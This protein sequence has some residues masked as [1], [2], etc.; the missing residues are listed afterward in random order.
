[1]A[2]IEITGDVR[3]GAGSSQVSAAGT[4]VVTTIIPGT[5]VSATVVTGGQGEQGPQGPAGVAGASVK[6]NVSPDESPD[7]ELT[8][9]TV[10]ESYIAGSLIVFLNGLA[11][12]NFTET[13]SETFTFDTAPEVGDIIK[14]AYSISD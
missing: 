1:M 7:G 12:A 10:P 13:T 3:G 14:L 9:F 4:S 11:E 8:V 2:D 6:G 5:I